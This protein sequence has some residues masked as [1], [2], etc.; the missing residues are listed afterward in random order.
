MPGAVQ[1][2]FLT[3]SSHFGR[4]S[5]SPTTRGNKIDGN[6]WCLTPVLRFRPT[7]PAAQQ[8]PL[9][10]MPKHPKVPLPQ[11]GGSPSY[12]PAI[13]SWTA[14][15]WMLSPCTK[16]SK[17]GN[18]TSLSLSFLLFPGHSFSEMAEQSVSPHLL[19]LVLP[20]ASSRWEDYTSPPC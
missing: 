11:M 2:F 1:S 6:L 15:W 7:S 4:E 18:R 20:L 16:A 14:H 19:I 10:S 12:F 8:G 3:S 13:S 9:A 17:A 5:L